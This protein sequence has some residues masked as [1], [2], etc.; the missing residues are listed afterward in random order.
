LS[1]RPADLPAW[2]ALAATLARLGAPARVF[3]SHGWQAVTGL[4]HV[5]PGSDVDLWV[6]V[7]D[8][9]QAD[10]VAAALEDAGPGIAP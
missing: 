6:A 5:G 10:A 8:A 2:D 3:G 1:R 9:V 7:A 4:A